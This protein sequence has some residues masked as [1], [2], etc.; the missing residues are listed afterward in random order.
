L[1]GVIALAV[2]SQTGEPRWWRLGLIPLWW[3]AALGFLQAQARTCVALAAKG[4]CDAQVGRQL[5]ESEIRI[6][7]RQARRVNI[8]SAIVTALVTLGALALP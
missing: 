3:V 6:L 8:R 4:V 1:I 2:L 5:D 7:N